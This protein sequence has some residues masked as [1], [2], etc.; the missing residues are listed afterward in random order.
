MAVHVMT[1]L[2]FIWLILL[3]GLVGIIFK[4]EWFG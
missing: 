3:L 2:F 1:T 4:D